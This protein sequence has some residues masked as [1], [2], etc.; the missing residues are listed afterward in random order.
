MRTLSTPRGAWARYRGMGRL[1]RFGVSLV[2]GAGLLLMGLASTAPVSAHTPSNTALTAAS[3]YVSVT[4]ARI[5]D[6]RAGSGEAYT[7]DTLAAGGMLQVQVPTSVVPAGATAVVLNVTAVDP[8]AAGYLTVLPGGETLPTGPN[9]PSNLNFA[10]NTTP[11][12]P[13]LVTVQLSSTGTV[14]IYNYTGS[15]N[16]VVDV[17]GYYLSP[18]TTSGLYTP[19]V[20]S[21]AFGTLT[22]GGAI[23]AGVTQA[24]AVAGASA[25]DEVPATASA[26]VLNVTAAHATAPS[27]LTVFPAGV[28]RPFASNLNFGA[29]AP[30]QAIANRVTVGVGTGGEIDVYNLQGTVNV[31]V[32][33]DGYY[34]GTGGVGSPFVAITPFRVADTVAGTTTYVGTETPIPADGQ[35]PNSTETFTLADA[36]IPVNAV[37]VAMN[38]TAVPGNKPGYLT[39]Y[40]TSTATPPVASDVN[41]TASESPGVPN[42]TIAMTTGGLAQNV[43]VANSYFTTGATVDVIADDFGYFAP[44]TAVGTYTVTGGGTVPPSTCTVDCSGIY[45]GTLHSA[46]VTNNTDNAGVVDYTASGFAAGASV[47]LALFPSTTAGAPTQPYYFTPSTADTAGTALNEGFSNNGHG[48]PYAYINTVDGNAAV[49]SSGYDYECDGII[50]NSSGEI[51]FALDSFH[52]DGT[53]PVVWTTPASAGSE[54]ALYVNAD[55][56][57]QTGYEVGIGP[58]TTWGEPVPAATLGEH[59]Y[60]YVQ[61]V[62]PLT[63]TFTGCGFD[64]TT[65]CYTF[66]YGAALD[67]Y[68]YYDDPTN[69][70]GYSISE[71]DF[72]SWLS[73]NN[74][75]YTGIDW[76]EPTTY[77]GD[78]LYID[79]GTSGAPSD[80]EMNIDVPA[81]PTAVQASV[82]PSGPNVGAISVKWNAPAPAPALLTNPSVDYY[83]IWMATESTTGT[84]DWSTSTPAGSSDTSPDVSV[85]NPGAG[86]Y[87]F[88]VVACTDDAPFG[89]GLCGPLDASAPLTIAAPAAPVIETVVITPSTTVGSALVTYNEDVTCA[90]NAGPDFTYSNTGGSGSVVGESTPTGCAS[91]GDTLTITFPASNVVAPGSGDT[92]KYTVPGTETAL[93]SVYAGPSGSPVYAAGQTVSDPGTVATGTLS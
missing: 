76:A 54:T 52:P 53:I 16:V 30:L 57:P 28:T 17:E 91:S 37:G 82:N 48:W 84:Y 10:A 19:L 58:A 22:I 75:P 41:W 72:A 87:E 1:P 83:D 59:E 24:V 51:T 26:V 68:E 32:D 21:R 25:T 11:A 18:Y 27:F 89:V 79:V 92:F 33:V 61:T 78:E 77:A 5:A 4:P 85:D 80:F 63:D 29:Q 49:C 88:A 40:P 90:V 66:T 55:G 86:T 15:T 60:V 64:A 34:S 70:T 6:T 38:L 9:L 31:D 7:G 45:D 12:V 39:S 3:S 81:A 67:T 23:G 43:E 35:S 93:N 46:S 42:F 14:E 74:Q 56:T 73:A 71:A 20:P 69:S 13:N 62:N 8:T 65:P 44:S 50:A 2:G 47:N 36:D